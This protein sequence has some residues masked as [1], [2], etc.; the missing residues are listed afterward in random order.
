MERILAKTNVRKSFTEHDL[1][2]KCVSDAAPLEHARASLVHADSRLTQ[3]VYRRRP[4]HV[5]PGELAFE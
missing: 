4:E 3:R 1:P 5:K 2:A